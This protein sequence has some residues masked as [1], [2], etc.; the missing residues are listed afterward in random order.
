MLEIL[1]SIYAIL[2]L[3]LATITDLKKREILDSISFTLLAISS[4]TVIIYSIILKDFNILLT[5]LKVFFPLLFL[6]LLLY[7]T[8]QWGGGDTKLL[9]ALS[10]PLA[11]PLIKFDLTLSSPIDFVTNLAIVG[12]LYGTFFAIIKTIRYPKEFIKNAKELTKEKKPTILISILISLLLFIL[13]YLLKSQLTTAL[14]YASA[15]FILITPMLFIIFKSVE[16]FSMIKTIPVNK[17]TPGDWIIDKNIK[18]KFKISE[19]GIEP[20]QILKLKKSKTKSIL[21]K[22]GL[23][24]APTFLL[25]YLITILNGNLV[26]NIFKLFF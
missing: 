5:T 4:I 9:I 24:F 26:L 8:R 11:F 21:I 17:L 2:A 19:L 10:I 22:E 25:A 1:L 18:S 12:A 14:L 16:K 3:L 15:I 20:E 6:S 7:F 13:G 23:P